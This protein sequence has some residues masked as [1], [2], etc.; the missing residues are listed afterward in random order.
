MAHPS[1]RPQE[2]FLRSSFSDWGC[3]EVVR[4]Q[5][6]NLPLPQCG[7]GETVAI[8]VGELWHGPTLAFKDLGLQV[9]AQVINDSAA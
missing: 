6:A 8:H 9:L 1:R 5:E 7:V 4:V 3:K 2:V